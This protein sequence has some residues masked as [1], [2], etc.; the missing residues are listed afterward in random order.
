MDVADIWEG[1]Y[2]GV[3]ASL[4]SIYSELGNEIVPRIESYTTIFEKIN[5]AQYGSGNAAFWH[6]WMSE[7]KNPDA[8][9]DVYT[10]YNSKGGAFFTNGVKIDEVDQWTDEA[11]VE[12]DSDKR[13]DLIKNATRKILENNGASVPYIQ[14]GLTSTLYW[15]Y[16]KTGRGTAFVDEQNH[17]LDR[18]FDKTDPT[19]QGRPA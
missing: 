1:R 14:L 2:R 8:T 12:Y 10:L 3:V 4:Q 19:W 7:V 9:L 5:G 15:N 11:I 18:W 13:I 16:A 17:H 6:G